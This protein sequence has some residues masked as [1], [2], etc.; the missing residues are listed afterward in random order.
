MFLYVNS[1]LIQGLDVKMNELDVSRKIKD[2]FETL[3][4]DANKQQDGIKCPR[5]GKVIV[6]PSGK[7]D[8]TMMH[9]IARSCYVEVKTV[10]R[11]ETSFSFSEIST[12]QRAKLDD[13][14]ARGGV[15]YLALGIIR[16]PKKNDRLSALYLIEWSHW[17]F[18]ERLLS[19][20]QKS[21]PVKVGPG[22]SKALQDQ[23]L[24]IESR[25]AAFALEQIKG[26]WRI[27][28]RH[29]AIDQLGTGVKSQ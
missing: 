10:R 4:Y 29:P 16:R 11:D 13:W 19:P 15:G 14:R 3:G 23:F 20:Y 8:R 5:C 21:I 24:D 25:S 1:A 26:G 9:P 28:A 22:F 18:I 12:E 2:V 6:P 27:P 7:P 17:T